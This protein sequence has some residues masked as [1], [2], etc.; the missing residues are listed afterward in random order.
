MIQKMGEGMTKLGDLINVLTRRFGSLTSELSN[1]S[2]K[3]GEAIVGVGKAVSGSFIGISFGVG[4]YDDLANQHRSAGEH[5]CIMRY[6][7]E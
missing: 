4:I 3:N 5:L 2:I 1:S 6:R 7:Q